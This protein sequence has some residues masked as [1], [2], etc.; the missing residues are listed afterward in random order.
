MGNALEQRLVNRVIAKAREVGVDVP[1][2]VLEI[3]ASL[4]HGDAGIFWD[5]WVQL[6]P[7]RDPD[8]P[9]LQGCCMGQAVYGWHRCTCW[10]PIYDVDQTDPILPVAEG[11]IQVRHA[12]CG[13]C[14]FKRGSQERA[15]RAMEEELLGLAIAGIPFWCHDGMRR[16]KLY[17]HPTLGDVPATG[18]DWR[19]PQ[20]AGVPFR[21]DG[22]PGL[23]CAG[24]AQEVKRQDRL[25]QLE[26]ANI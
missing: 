1:T 6:H 5:K 9:D 11:S 19:P 20:V 3:A 24:W 17:R 18:D 10:E 14:A 8:D 26:E 7:D 13:D 22:S 16:P 2:E 23:L 12:R 4:E 21:R 15:D 25:T